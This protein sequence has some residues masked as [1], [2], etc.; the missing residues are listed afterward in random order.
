MRY[1]TTV[2][3]ALM[4]MRIAPVYGETATLTVGY[5]YGLGYLP[6]HVME[7]Q[8]LIEKHARASGV[9]VNVKY[10]NMGS[11]GILRDALLS[12]QVDFAAL[13]PPALIFLADKTNGEF[14]MAANIASLP[15]ILNT[16]E[17]VRSICDLKGKIAMSAVKSSVYAIAL[18]MASKQHCND[19]FL[20]DP[21]TVT[22]TNP[23]GMTAL[24]NGQ[25]SSHFSS[26]P[27]VDFELKNSNGRIR[28][29]LNSYDAFQGPAALIVLI[30]PDRFRTQNPKVYSAMLAALGESM[31]WINSHRKEAATLYLESEHSNEPFDAVVAQLSSPDVIFD[32]TPRQISKF[33]HFMREV[34][35]AKKEWDWKSLSS[36]N[37][38]SL[39][40]S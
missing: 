11:S 29:I 28:A 38:L 12:N 5:Q 27:F 21:N 37:L 26:Y 9:Q 19:P 14:K 20:L 34:G 32:V 16:T 1:G 10:L 35:T 17:G 24:I 36:P 39:N 6:F 18:Q 4:L 23:E 15:M 40:G 31:L 33:A 7:K 2:L 3:V 13:G 8:S 25:V 22:M 30:G